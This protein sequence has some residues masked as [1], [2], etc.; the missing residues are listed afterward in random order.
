MRERGEYLEVNEISRMEEEEE[1]E[2]GAAMIAMESNLSA[3][4]GR[5]LRPA[6][7]IHLP[8]YGARGLYSGGVRCFSCLCLCRVVRVLR[9]DLEARTKY[10]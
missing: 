1:E 10:P 8:A 4:M 3:A 2:E 7:S 5:G 6:C 9:V